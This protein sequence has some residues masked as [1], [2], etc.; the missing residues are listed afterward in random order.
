MF[1]KIKVYQRAKILTIETSASLK[2]VSQAY[3]YTYTTH[4][5]TNMTQVQILNGENIMI[6]THVK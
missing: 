3:A 5:G 1:D 2:T 6:H 4:L